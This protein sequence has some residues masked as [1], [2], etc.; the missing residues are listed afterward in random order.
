M[1]LLFRFTA[2]L[3]FVSMSADAFQARTLSNGVGRPTTIL[4]AKPD[5]LTGSVG[6][7]R[8]F[9]VASTAFAFSS[10][11]APNNP[12]VAQGTEGETKTAELKA[13]EKAKI[14]KAQV[15]MDE[16]TKKAEE[17]A[18]LFLEARAEMDD[19]TKKQVEERLR[20]KAADDAKIA[21]LRAEEE[22]RMRSEK[23]K[24]RQSER[25]AKVKLEELGK[26]QAEERSRLKAD[27]ETR[28]A[29]LK[30]ESIARS[31][32]E[33]EVIR[34]AEE[35]ARIAQEALAK[36]QAE[37]RAKL[38]AEE[39]ARVENVRVKANEVRMRTEEL[40]KIL[41]E[42]SNQGG[43]IAREGEKISEEIREQLK[44]LNDLGF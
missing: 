13:E 24:I 18:K 30:A 15:A 21:T 5:Q 12:A 2:V 17:E 20:A 35:E 41:K 44:L 43:S 1:K 37:E 19:L 38:R 6:S 39:E 16:L 26:I 33:K 8:S 25:E 27:E 10:V 4:E 7:R 3:A 40:L 11:S 23:E 29:K 14:D 22:A 9:L 32:R 42:S 28:I 36:R 34:K 31:V